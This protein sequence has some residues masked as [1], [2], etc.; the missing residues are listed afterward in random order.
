VT[1]EAAGAAWGA[2]NVEPPGPLSC[3]VSPACS[4]ID[5]FFGF[6]SD[7]P[8]QSIMFENDFRNGQSFSASHLLFATSD[9]APAPGTISL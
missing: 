9:P 1:M 6:T 8:F 2:L 4:V 5:G 7:V 3:E